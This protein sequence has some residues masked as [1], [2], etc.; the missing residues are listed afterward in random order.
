MAMSKDTGKEEYLRVIN[1]YLFLSTQNFI[2]RKTTIK[3]I[4][5]C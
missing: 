5:G 3:K 2:K 4:M 1:K